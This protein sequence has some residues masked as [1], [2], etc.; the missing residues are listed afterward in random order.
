MLALGLELV[1][2]LGSHSVARAAGEVASATARGGV[3]PDAGLRGGSFLWYFMLAS[4]P[5]IVL[6]PFGLRVELQQ[7]LGRDRLR[8]LYAPAFLFLGA[9]TALV[10]VGLYTGSHRYY[11]PVLPAL[12]LLAAGAL[13]GRRLLPLGAV[14]ASAA[15][16]AS[17]VPVLTGLSATN[18]G[19]VAAGRASARVPGVLMT[20]SPVAAFWSRKPPSEIIG[21]RGL[22]LDYGQAVNQLRR[23]HITSVVLE[24]ID[25]YRAVS[26][27]PALARGQATA[28]FLPLGQQRFYSVAGG[29]AAYAYAL[30]PAEYRAPLADGINACIHLDLQP[31]RGKTA[32]LEKGLVL[33][34]A[35]RDLAGEGMGFGVPIVRYGDGWTY[36]GSA[37]L[38]D[39]SDPVGVTWRK[40]FELDRVGGDLRHGYRFEP[41][42]SRGRIE[43]TYQLSDSRINIR[44]RPIWLAPGSSEI[45]LLNEESSAFDDYAD[46]GRSL[47]GAD[48]GRWLPAA[49][50]WARLRSQALDS[51]WSIPA[52]PP[53]AEMVAGREH[54]PP[55]LDWGGIE[56]RYPAPF[57]QVR[58]AVTVRGAR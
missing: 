26:V 1:L 40:T 16:L 31:A 19:L 23:D 18:A 35:G 32:G 2:G 27:F 25:Y 17:F 4:L 36:S 41:A 3:A 15:L 13:E 9:T 28:P 29:K 30:H 22:P 20:D 47:V 37:T 45:V 33:E 42:A 46:A 11:F 58:Y 53:P 14:A 52:P 38:V 57:D 55:E 24:D 7:P 6:A 10:W 48:F 49:G 50:A 21:S 34:R 56:Y 39:V 12:A 51:E 44:V 5:L 8:L 43:V 54:Q